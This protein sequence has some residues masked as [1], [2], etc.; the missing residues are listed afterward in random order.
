[1]QLNETTDAALGIVD[2]INSAALIESENG[3]ILLRSAADIRL[4]G[5]ITSTLGDIG[6]VAVRDV[7]QSSAITTGQNFVIESGGA[8]TMQAG[9]SVTAGSTALALVGSN[10]DLYLLS[11]TTVSL[12]ATGDIRRCQRWRRA[13]HRSSEFDHAF[14]GS[15]RCLRSYRC[16]EC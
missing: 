10:I 13:E 5:S 12:R 9:A 14:A 16:T 15:D 3:D 7:I 4:S 6:L 11:A 8:W 1:M 2:G